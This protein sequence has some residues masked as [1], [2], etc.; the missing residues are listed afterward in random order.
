[1]QANTPTESVPQPTSTPSPTQC[2]K[3][4]CEHNATSCKELYQCNPALPS[5]FYYITTPQ[6][7]ER[8]YCEMNAT[9]CGNIT[10]GWMRAP[11]IDMTDPGN[12][13]PENLTYTNE[14][15]IR[16]C[17]SFHTRVGCISVFFPAHNLPYTKVCGRAFGYQFASTK[18]F[19]NPEDIIYSRFPDRHTNLSDTYVSGLSVTYGSPR[20]H[21]WAFQGRQVQLHQLPLCTLPWSSCTSI[22]GRERFCESGYSPPDIWVPATQVVP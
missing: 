5:G 8:V 12:T 6:G 21:I 15:S 7:V 4:M 3:P 22:C 13:C 2:S 9:N 11:Y 10:G 18:G 19:N 1:M 14:S 17:R 16:L 20:S